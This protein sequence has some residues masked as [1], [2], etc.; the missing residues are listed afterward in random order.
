MGAGKLGRRADIDKRRPG[1]DRGAH[2]RHLLRTAPGAGD[3]IA[4]KADGADRQRDG[5]WVHMA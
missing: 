4:Q 1:R 3:A 2:Q 5:E